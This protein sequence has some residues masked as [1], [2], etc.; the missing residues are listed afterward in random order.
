MPLWD[1]LGLGAWITCQLPVLPSASLL[2]SLGSSTWP[3]LLLM[4]DCLHAAGCFLCPL[5]SRCTKIHQTVKCESI[6]SPAERGRQGKRAWPSCTLC[7]SPGHLFSQK[8]QPFQVV[9]VIKQGF[10]FF[11]QPNQNLIIN[12]FLLSKC[13]HMFILMYSVSTEILS[14]SLLH[15]CKYPCLCLYLVHGMGTQ[16][17]Q[18]HIHM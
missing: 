13:V 8:P 5:S 6:S 9:C 4:K 7:L 11:P 16:A 14:V 2:T 10:V 18:V 3:W 1:A 17:I 12:S 15:T